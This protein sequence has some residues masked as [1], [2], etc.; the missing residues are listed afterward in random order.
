MLSRVKQDKITAQ[1]LTKLESQTE[2]PFGPNKK[3]CTIAL[4]NLC[5]KI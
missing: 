2:G 1:V 5:Y 4:Y 3:V